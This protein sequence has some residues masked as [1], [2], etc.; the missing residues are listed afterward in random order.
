MR[1]AIA[2]FAAAVAMTGPAFAQSENPLS[3]V[4]RSGDGAATVRIAPCQGGSDYCGVVLSEKLQPNEPS[5]LGKVVIKDIR[6][7]GPRRWTGAYI[8]DGTTIKARIQQLSPDVMAFKVCAMA[9]ICST[10]KYSRI[11]R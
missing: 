11:G 1:I 9:F 8:A 10:E 2:F 6:P 3:G 5:M 4:W 7:A